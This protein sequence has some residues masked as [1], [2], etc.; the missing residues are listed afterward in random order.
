[1]LY[2][3]VTMVELSSETSH[4]AFNSTID[5]RATLYRPEIDHDGAQISPLGHFST[6]GGGVRYRARMI[7]WE[8]GAVRRDRYQSE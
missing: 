6:G 7:R 8:S 3:L 4:R 1:M 2:F 5:G